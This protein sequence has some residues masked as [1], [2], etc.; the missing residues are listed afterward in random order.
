M[1][2]EE[3]IK[4]R[5]KT[6]PTKTPLSVEIRKSVFMLM[7]TLLSIIILVS[8]VYLMNS[9][10]STQKGYSIK[11]ED[12]QKTALNEEKQDLIRKI[13]EAQSFKQIENS[14]L[15][16]SMVTPEETIYFDPDKEKK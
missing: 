13:I 2:S 3:I 14:E 9:S 1:L 11:Q 7:F 15:V 6:I 10:Q 12:L 16:K 4:R 8:I 5:G